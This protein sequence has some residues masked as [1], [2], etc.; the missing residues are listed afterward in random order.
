[1][2]SGMPPAVFRRQRRIGKHYFDFSHF[3]VSTVTDPILRGF[4]QR[5]RH[6]REALVVS[7]EQQATVGDLDR[8][9]RALSAL[10]ETEG[11]TEGSVVALAAPNGPGFLAGLL[12]IRRCRCAA[13]LYDWRTPPAEKARIARSLGVAATLDGLR[14]WPRDLDDFTVLPGAAEPAKLP[15]DTAVVKLT[16]G[17]TG[18]P[19]GIVTPSS[20]LV[21]DDDALAA[22]ME[23]QPDDRILAMIPMSHSYGLSSTVL[24]ALMRRSSLVV[25]SEHGAPFDPLIS[26]RA[27]GVTFF[28]TVP[29]VLQ[30]LVKRTEPPRLPPSLRLVISAGEPLRAATAI[31]FRRIYGQPV[32]VFYGASES[33]GIAFDRTGTAAER[34]TVGTPVEG[35]RIF[36]EPLEDEGEHKSADRVN[37]ASDRGVVVVE[38]PAV[39]SGYYPDS[40]PTLCRDRYR[41]QDMAAFHAGELTLEGRLDDLINVRGRK[42]NPREVEAVLSRL[43]GVEEAIVLGIL[44]PGRAETVVRSFLVCPSGGISRASVQAWCRRHLAHYKVP[45]SIVW[46]DELPRTERGKLDRAALRRMEPVLGPGSAKPVDPSGHG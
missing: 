10:L 39:A 37:G 29:A 3:D 20:A 6:P 25:A 23:L 40:A 4:R 11:V 43:D 12:A 45:R 16:S 18:C 17:S 35:V 41:S 30:A 13:L 9:A 19:R 14:V 31:A 28:P 46:L 1:M 15:P 26:A 36:L 5:L 7:R 34:G 2:P 22:T 42:V 8:M 32:H 27:H 44:L 38:S 33:G 21:A 24:P